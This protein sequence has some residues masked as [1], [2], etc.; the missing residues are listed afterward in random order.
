M[1]RPP[2]G[3]PWFNPVLQALKDIVCNPGEFYGACKRVRRSYV[4]PEALKRATRTV[5]KELVALG[6]GGGWLDRTEIETEKYAIDCLGWFQSG[7]I[8]I[9]R[10]SACRA[11]VAYI[12]GDTSLVGTLRHEYGHAY[13]YCHENTANFQK[14]FRRTRGYNPEKHIS[15]YASKNPEEDFCEVFAKFVGTK[16]ALT[17]DYPCV[18]KKISYIRK[19]CRRPRK[20]RTTP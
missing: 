6:F 16:G 17:S 5:K 11:Y 4:T 15:L 18:A 2:R 1:P 12:N 19:L 7:K 8:V 20:P 13:L 10:L 3:P 14:V 9:P